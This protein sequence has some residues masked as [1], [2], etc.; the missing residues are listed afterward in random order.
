MFALLVTLF[1]TGLFVHIAGYFWLVV[2]AYR[3]APG[4]GRVALFVWPLAFLVPFLRWDEV[5]LKALLLA[6]IGLAM[7]WTGYH[8]MWK[9]SPAE[10]AAPEFRFD[11]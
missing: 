11:K 9:D 1:I 4:A 7:A 5:V 8:F 6:G 10:Q 3:E 2:L